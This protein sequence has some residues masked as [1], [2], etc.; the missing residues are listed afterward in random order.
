MGKRKQRV[1]I[2]QK[3]KNLTVVR[4]LGK[5]NGDNHYQSL[6]R[7][8]CGNEFVIRDTFLICGNRTQCPR[9]SNQDKIKHGMTDT[10]IYYL[11]QGMKDRCLNPNNKRF[12]DYGGRGI[13]VCNEW[14]DSDVFIEWAIENGWEEGLQIDRIDVDGNYEPANCRFVT[15]LENA[16]N[17]RNTVF[18]HYEGKLMPIGEVA[19]ITGLR[20]ELI[21]QRI[22]KFG[23]SEYDATHIIPDSK[24]FSTKAM[25][26]TVITD[27]ETGEKHY[28]DSCSKASRFIGQSSTYLLGASYRHGKR[29]TS[30]KYLIEISD[31]EENEALCKA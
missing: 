31:K 2:G 23:W 25:R 27:M 5:V 16:R 22:H 9:C 24:Y 12:N 4:P 28:F 18:I 20:H 26:K 8:T 19:D 13:S 15:Q 29:F 1:E 7:C 10:S 21:Y 17:R 6:V 14:L 30:G 3:F 11:W